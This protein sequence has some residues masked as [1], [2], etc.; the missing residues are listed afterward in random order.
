MIFLSIFLLLCIVEAIV[1]WVKWEEI[2]GFISISKLAINTFGL[3]E[4]F[5]GVIQKVALFFV[6]NK[7]YAWLFVA[8]IL[9]ANLFVAFM[10]RILIL[11]FEILYS[12]IF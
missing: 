5:T 8:L 1:I 9:S 7:K 3:E 11:C 2:S 12:A 6:K 4:K 10:L